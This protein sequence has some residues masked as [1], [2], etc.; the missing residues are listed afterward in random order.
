MKDCLLVGVLGNQKAGKNTTWHTLFDKKVKTGKQKLYFGNK[1]YVEIF[2]INGSSEE[3][4]KHI[5]EIVT[6]NAP[7]IV[8]C[9]MPYKRNATTT[10]DYFVKQNYF[11]F[12]HWLN[13]GYNDHGEM[14]DSLGLIQKM[15]SDEALV[16]IRNG[17]VDP[18]SRV[19]EIRNLVYGWATNKGLVKHER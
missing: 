9:T 5:G 3:H 17:K 2:L 18:A 15:L 11:L 14:T 13:P 12:V 10:I 7:S 6:P 1:E 16:G 8:L 4:K 19:R